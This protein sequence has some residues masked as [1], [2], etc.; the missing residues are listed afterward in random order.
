MCKRTIIAQ[1]QGVSVT[2]CINCRTVNI[3]K[4]GMLMR[5]SFDQFTEFAKITDKIDFDS[6]LEYA[7]DGSEVV[8]LST[9]CND[10]CLMFTRQEL[11]NFSNVINEA[12]YMQSIYKLVHE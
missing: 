2:Q 12:I 8:I 1:K 11:A 9:P 7:P 4:T 6:Y 10:I 5:F 3:W